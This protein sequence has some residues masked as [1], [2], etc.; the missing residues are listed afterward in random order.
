METKYEI[1]FIVA[2]EKSTGIEKVKKEISRCA[3]KILEETK[4]DQR[5]LSYPIKKHSQGFYITFIFDLEKEK[6]AE[7]EEAL[8]L[9]PEILRYL[10]VSAPEKIEAMPVKPPAPK[11]EPLLKEKLAAKIKIVEKPLKK[12]VETLD[13]KERLKKLDEELEKLLKE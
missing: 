8:K 11:E 9:E 5:N 7:L 3:G 13:E 12:P 6:L 10:L 2:D 4:S 1:T